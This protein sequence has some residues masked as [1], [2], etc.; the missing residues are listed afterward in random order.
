[1][2]S[3]ATAAQVFNKTVF[4]DITGATE[5]TGQLLAFDDN[6]RSGPTSRRRI[7]EVDPDVIVPEVIVDCS[8]EEVFLA[9]RGSTDY[10]RANPVRRKYPVIP[11]E[12][13]YS[14]R[15]IKEMLEVSAGSTEWGAI[16]YSR[17]EKQ[18]FT[19]DYAGGHNFIFPG[20]LEI[21][22]GQYVSVS[23]DYYRARENSHVDELGFSVVEVV[24]L[25]N[26]LQTLDITVK[27]TF[28]PATETTSGDVT[29]PFLCVVEERSKAY[30]YI[31]DDYEDGEGVDV[32]IST[33]NTTPA[34]SIVGG[35]V[36]VNVNVADSVN[37]LHCRKV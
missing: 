12:S 28:D 32:T 15:T 36:V 22:A 33:M 7:L 25:P 30:T 4:T 20:S 9:A 21:Q 17:R 3:L 19:S 14:I 23:T 29:A 31:R 8:T 26:V 24:K 11:S 37:V 1:M 13:A 5:F 18:D 27:G 2:M 6:I 10:F 16:G 35:Y 34:G